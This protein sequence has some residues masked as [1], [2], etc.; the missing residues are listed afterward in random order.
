MMRRQPPNPTTSSAETSQPSSTRG[1]AASLIMLFLYFVIYL[2]RS[3][4]I[5]HG[6]G[7]K[8]GLHLSLC[9]SV[10]VS[11]CPHCQSH[12]LIDFH[13]NW[14]RPKNPQKYKQVSWGSTSHHPFP[15][16]A[17]KTPILGQEVLNIHA[18]INYPISALNVRES[19]KFPRFRK[20]EA[21]VACFLWGWKQMLQDFCRDGEIFCGNVA[22]FDFCTNKCIQHPFL[23]CAKLLLHV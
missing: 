1:C 23:S 7:Y 9:L 22:V 3:Y 15:H 21:C 8:I 17:P 2:P 14:H 5:Q 12:F 20:L 13:Q 6:T 19:P 18:N 11:I 4:C 10:C 16:F